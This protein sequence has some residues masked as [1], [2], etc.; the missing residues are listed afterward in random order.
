MIKWLF[1]NFFTAIDNLLEKLKLKFFESLK[2][3]L[4]KKFQENE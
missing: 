2:T 1:Y 3:F 4:K